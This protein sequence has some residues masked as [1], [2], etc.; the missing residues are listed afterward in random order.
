MALRRI[1]IE[2]AAARLPEIVRQ[3][4]DGEEIVLLE[5]T[6]PVTKIVPISSAK[7]RARRESMKGMVVGIAEDFDRTPEGF[8]VERGRFIAAVD[9]G[10]QEM[11]AGLGQDARAA[12][13]ELR[14]KLAL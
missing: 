12:L 3:A 2:E 11:E 14:S 13:G 8:D 7:P 5:G 9:K 6:V 4:G 1:S 10:I